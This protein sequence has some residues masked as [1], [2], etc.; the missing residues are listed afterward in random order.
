MGHNFVGGSTMPT[1]FSI[2]RLIYLRTSLVNTCRSRKGRVTPKIQGEMLF[3]KK[4]L[5]Y[6]NKSSDR[7]KMSPRNIFGISGVTRP[8]QERL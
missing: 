8:L 4:D 5:N 2:Y 6:K 3:G 7:R 1:V